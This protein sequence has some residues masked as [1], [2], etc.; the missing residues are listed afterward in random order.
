MVHTLTHEVE[1]SKDQIF[2]R[3]YYFFAGEEISVYKKD[4]VAGFWYGENLAGKRGLFPSM[5]VQE[6]TPKSALHSSAD[7]ADTHL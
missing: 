2:S 3:F 7:D 6:D 4:D 1:N 5:C